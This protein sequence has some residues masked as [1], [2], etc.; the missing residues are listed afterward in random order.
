MFYFSLFLC[1]YGCTYSSDK[2]ERRGL[3]WRKIPYVF[4]NFLWDNTGSNKMPGIYIQYTAWMSQLLCFL[5]TFTKFIIYDS[6]F[7]ILF[8]FDFIFKFS[9]LCI[10]CVF[11]GGVF[12]CLSAGV[13]NMFLVVV[14]FVF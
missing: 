3:R 9:F 5:I 8:L 1:L 2:C 11:Q 12:I 4:Y 10:L 13:Y 6:Y 14:S 7:V